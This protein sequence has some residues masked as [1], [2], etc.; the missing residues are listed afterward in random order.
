MAQASLF[1][2]LVTVNTRLLECG[3]VLL[4]P[5]HWPQ[6]PELGVVG[7]VVLDM[8]MPSVGLANARCNNPVSMTSQKYAMMIKYFTASTMRELVIL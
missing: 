6:S 5:P 8:T 1:A 3:A 2:S 4:I 7:I